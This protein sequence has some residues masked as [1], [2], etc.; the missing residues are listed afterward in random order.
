MEPEK[1]IDH[2]SPGLLVLSFSVG[3]NIVYYVPLRIFPT[4]QAAEDFKNEIRRHSQPA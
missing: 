1:A 4:G 2:S 3:G